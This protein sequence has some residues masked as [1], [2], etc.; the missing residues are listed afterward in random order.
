MIC[1]SNEGKKQAKPAPI[2]D[3][4]YRF[5]FFSLQVK[6]RKFLFIDKF[7]AMWHTY[8]CLLLIHSSDSICNYKVVSVNDHAHK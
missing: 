4:T 6:K 8:T 3:F 1:V 2:V 5:A 7:D